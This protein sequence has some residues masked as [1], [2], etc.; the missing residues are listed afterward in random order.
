[1]EA[2]DSLLCSE[3]TGFHLESLQ[4]GQLLHNLFLQDP[5]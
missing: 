1:M 2:E 5:S 4:L 3:Y